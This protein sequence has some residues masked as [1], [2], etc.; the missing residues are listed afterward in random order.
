MNTSQIPSAYN[1]QSSEMQAGIQRGF[2]VRVYAWMTLGLVITTVSAFFT[3]AI[4]GVIE[5]IF[6]NTFI[7][8]GLLVA[9]LALVIILSAAINRFPPAV[10]GLLFTG[11]AVLN[12]VTLSLIF[13]EYTSSTIAVTFGVTAC[14][15]GVMTLFGFTTHRDLTKL[16]SLLIM[17]LIGMVLASVVNL[18]FNNDVVYWITTYVGVLIFVGLVAYDTQKLKRMSLTVGGNGELAQRASIL[19]ALALYLDFI[20]LFLLLLRILGRR[21]R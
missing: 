3:L 11:Y 15:F 13:L 6:S 16:G 21:R 20:N 4:P 1:L 2:L 9:E 7:F 10:A 14:T 18:F 5:T 19:G 12:G 17:A 8:I